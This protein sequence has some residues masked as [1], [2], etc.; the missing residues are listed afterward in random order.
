MAYIREEI[1]P[2]HNGMEDYKTLSETQIVDMVEND[3]GKYAKGSGYYS[4]LT[5]ILWIIKYINKGRKSCEIEKKKPK[6]KI[7]L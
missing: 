3:R 7:K 2:Y 1:V 6:P 4:I 5:Y